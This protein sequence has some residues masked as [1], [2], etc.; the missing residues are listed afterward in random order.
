M[1]QL[2]LLHLQGHQLLAL[3]VCHIV[4]CGGCVGWSGVALR[5]GDAPVCLVPP[6][7]FLVVERSKGKDVQKEQGR[8]NRDG[9]AELCGVVPF[10]LNHHR[11]LIGQV[12]A[13]ALV[14]GL[15]G[16]GRWDPWVAGGGRPVVFARE[17]F[18]VRVGGGVLWR[19]LG[20]GGDIL[21]K[22]IYV[23]EVRN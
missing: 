21:E 16:V 8:P 11:R 2:L 6:L 3:Q 13:L 1:L 23:V 9:D 7:V 17:T 18:G 22:F 15:L 20:G 12:A 10:G 14:G 19:Y 4:G 5:S